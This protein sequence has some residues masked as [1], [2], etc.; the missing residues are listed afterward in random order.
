MK[1]ALLNDAGGLRTFA[2]VLATG[3]EVMS[4]LKRFA[5]DQRLSAS[6]FSAIGA[7]SD[8][9]VAFFDWTTKQYR[10]SPITE[11]VEVLSLLGDVTFD[12]DA[13]TVHAHVVIG[14]SDTSARGG[15][16]V[17]AHV[18]PTLEVI[19][20]ELPRHLHRRFDPASGLALIDP[21]DASRRKG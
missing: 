21:G 14:T 8:A 1:S 2:V 5:S 10:R 4:T 13:R 20:T 9:V 15:H 16:L 6:Q 3:D 7:F 17:E 12:G 19:I 11:Q 18:R